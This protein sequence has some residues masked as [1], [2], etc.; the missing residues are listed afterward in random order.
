MDKN[1]VEKLCNQLARNRL[2]EPEEIRSMYRRWKA[3]AGPAVN[4]NA[5]FNKWLVGNK[6]ITEFQLGLV[7]RGFG[8]MLYLGE[9]KLIERIG[10]GRM[11]GVYKAVHTSGQ[12]AAIKVLPPSKAKHPALLAR[13]RREARLAERLD[14]DNVV[15]SFHCGDTQTGLPYIVMEFL[16]GET[17]EDVLERRKRL[18]VNEAIAI[19]VQILDGLQHLHEEGIVHR[20]LKPANTML[21]PAWTPDKPDTTTDAE[22]KILDIGLSR[23]LFDEGSPG[24][25]LDLTADGAL[26]GTPNYLAPEQA[27]SAHTADIRADI[28]SVG[29]IIYEMLTGVT[30]FAE[31]N[32]AKQLIRHATEQARPLKEINSAVP[33]ALNDIVMT[34]LSK[35]PALRYAVPNQAAKALRELVPAPTRESQN[36]PI[37][38]FVKWLQAQPKEQENGVAVAKQNGTTPPAAP[39]AVAVAPA[40]PSPVTNPG[41]TTPLPPAAPPLQLPPLVPAALP[42]NGAQPMVPT[43]LVVKPP[44]D[45]I[46]SLPA[47]TSQPK[48]PFLQRQFF[49]GLLTGRDL[50]ACGTGAA[51]LVLLQLVVRGM[52]GW[53]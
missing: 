12:L 40:A 39:M 21:V 4:D 30:P 24:D 31:A 3:E 42:V 13:F 35:D 33:D 15:R 38:A 43:A 27:R 50:A 46:I 52:F 7:E 34:M 1:S 36:R 29:C 37:P 47:T 5:R 28:Y 16:D 10:H 32:L 6:F 11:A 20:D 25:P 48:V 8:E 49:R 45:K 23:A 9:Y 44:S 26:L 2:L 41:G 53:F 51:I 22:L 18:P 17:L 14:H 19:A